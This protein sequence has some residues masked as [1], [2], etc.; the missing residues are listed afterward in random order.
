M[1]TPLGEHSTSCMDVR[2]QAMAI[3]GKSTCTVT[4]HN[5]IKNTSKDIQRSGPT[6]LCGTPTVPCSAKPTVPYQQMDGRKDG[7]IEGKDG[8]MVGGKDGWREG[9]D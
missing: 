8:W 1:L 3:H 9:M 4:L 6:C 5:T 2:L 7:C